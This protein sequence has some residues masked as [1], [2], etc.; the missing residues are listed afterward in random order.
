MTIDAIEA[1]KQSITISTD[2]VHQYIGVIDKRIEAA[3]ADGLFEIEVHVPYSSRE[4]LTAFY[5]DLRYNVR[6]V[7][8]I[9]VLVIK[10]DSKS[11]K[12]QQ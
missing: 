8:P 10:W 7:A 4:A 11:I 6:I 9:S 3:I 2:P 5:R 1:N 12:E